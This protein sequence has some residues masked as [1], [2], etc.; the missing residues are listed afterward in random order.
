[1]KKLLVGIS[2][3][4]M[5]FLGVSR[6]EAAGAARGGKPSVAVNYTTTVTTISL[7][8]PA[9]LYSV[10]MTTG[11]AGDFIAIFDTGAAVIPLINSGQISAASNLKTRIFGVGVASQT[12]VNFDPP[13]QFNNG[14]VA[15]ASSA[16]SAYLFVFEKGRVTQGY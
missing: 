8:S 10:I 2:F 6:A 1:M 16:N 14:I 15:A 3:A 12:V 5:C 11:V 9:V 7:Q 4:A 13:L